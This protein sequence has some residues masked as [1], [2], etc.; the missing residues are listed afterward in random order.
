MN[1]VNVET[2]PLSFPLEVPSR[3]ATGVWDSWD[4]VIVRITASD[5]TVGYGEIGPVHGGG[6]LA[7]KALVDY[8]IAPRILGEDPMDRERL[9]HKMLGQG[10]GAY[11]FGEKGAIVSAIAGIEI[12]LWDLTGKILKTPV[13]QLLG[14]RVL[15]RIPAYASGFFGKEGRPLRPKE[16]AEEAKRYAE[17]GFK[18]IKMKIG[19]GRKQDLQNLEA[20][21]ST[22]GPDFG[23]M[24]DA[25]QGFTVA[26]VLKLSNELAAFDLTFLEEPISIHD[27]E[28][29]S[30]LSATVPI[31]LAAGEN[32]Y[33]HREFKDLV[34]QRAVS[35]VQPDVIH[36]GG[37]GEAKK[38]AVLA[39]TFG[40]ALSPHIHATIGV[41]A[42]IQLLASCP[43]TLAAEYITSGG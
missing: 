22:L 41:A 15:S 35:V 39:Q 12:A 43:H 11:A 14:G 3:D 37:I 28:G 16:C 13:Y 18:G 40:M 21:R 1:I 23:I 19:Y 10:T 29:M 8:R 27:V 33:T 20:V 42:S 36:V 2:F 31:P 32:Y 24:V 6:V 30:H 7:F 5:G 26:Q 4:T 9:F 34:V 25:N 38:V 17:Q